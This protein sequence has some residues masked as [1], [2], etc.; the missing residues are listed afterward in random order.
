MQKG[1]FLGL[2]EFKY[3]NF[4]HNLKLDRK[5]KLDGVA[6]LIAD[7][8]PA[9]STNMHSRVACQYRNLGFGKP[10]YYPVLAK[11]KQLFS[12]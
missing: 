10:A 8:P 4:S 11:H 3:T 1:E 2:D 9:N 12:Q 6:P 5:R 7:P